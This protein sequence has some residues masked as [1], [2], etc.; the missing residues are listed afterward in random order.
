MGLNALFRKKKVEDILNQ[1]DNDEHGHS[2][3]R[4]LTVRD[5]AAPPHPPTG[6]GWGVQL[7]KRIAV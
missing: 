4:H 7:C 5:L 3:G 2:L 1:V 6:R